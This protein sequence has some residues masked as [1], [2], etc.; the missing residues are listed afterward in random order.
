MKKNIMFSCVLL[1]DLTVILRPKST[2]FKIFGLQQNALEE[3]HSDFNMVV[4][5]TG[6]Q[7]SKREMS[8]RIIGKK[9]IVICWLCNNFHLM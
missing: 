2:A 5:L 8:L 1:I 4:Q 6:I 9:S 3:L 7:I